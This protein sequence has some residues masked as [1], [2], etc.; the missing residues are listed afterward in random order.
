VR[1]FGADPKIF[2]GARV[3]VLGKSCFE[4]CKHIVEIEFE[5]GSGLERIGAAALRDCESLWSIDLPTSVRIIKESSF[6]GCHEL[7]SC[8]IAKDLSLVTIG[9]RAFANCTSLRSFS[10]PRLVEQ[11][12]SQCFI[13]CIYLSRLKFNSSKPLQRVFDDRQLDDLLCEF[14]M[15]TSSGLFRIDIEDE[16]VDLKFPGWISIRHGEGIFDFSLV[17]DLE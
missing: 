2:V 10:I 14:G 9:D 8:F 6:E 11:I 16:D 15:R 17:R 12:G 4:S 7:E 1:Y 5:L 13:E 3:K